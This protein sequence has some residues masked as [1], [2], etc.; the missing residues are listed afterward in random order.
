MRISKKLVGLSKKV[1][2]IIERFC[3]NVKTVLLSIF[4]SIFQKCIFESVFLKEEF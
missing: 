2:R 3:Q 4:E 1:A